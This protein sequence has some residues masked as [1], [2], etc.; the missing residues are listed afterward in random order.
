MMGAT[1][2]ISSGTIFH[3]S[4]IRQ[5]RRS[6]QIKTGQEQREQHPNLHREEFSPPGEGAPGQIGTVRQV[7]QERDGPEAGE[8]ECPRRRG[9]QRTAGLPEHQETQGPDH[10][11]Q[12]GEQMAEHRDAEHRR[13]G[14]KQAR[15][16]FDH[17]DQKTQV[18]EAQAERPAIGELPGQSGG[19]V[20]PV[21][22]E[23]FHQGVNRSPGRGCQGDQAGEVHGAGHEVDRRGKQEETSHRHQ[24]ESHPVGQED[25]QQHDDHGREGEVE[26]VK[27]KTREPGVGPAQ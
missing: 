21:D 8:S 11:Q 27:G 25:V 24:L 26:V 7:G 19:H 3:V 14:G 15:L 4:P 23:T 2:V 6:D 1:V 12:S 5:A 17:P 10:Q 16:A 20:P 22:A 13:G 9:Y 18:D